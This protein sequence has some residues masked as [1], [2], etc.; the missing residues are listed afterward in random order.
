MGGGLI[1]LSMLFS[2]GSEVPQTQQ[3]ATVIETKTQPTT[4]ES[5]RSYEVLV[6]PEKPKPAITTEEKKFAPLNR[7]V[8][9]EPVARLFDDSPSYSCNCSKTCTQMISCDEAYYQLNQCGC[10]KRDGDRDGVPCE[11]IC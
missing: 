5:T 3:S 8:E 1:A 10:S 6:E 4:V 9:P 7:A 11:S 2:G